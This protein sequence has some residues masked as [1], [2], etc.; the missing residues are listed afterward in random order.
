MAAEVLER[1]AEKGV[2]KLPSREGDL[3][4][5]AEALLRELS[6]KRPQQVLDAFVGDMAAG[7]IPTIAKNLPE[8]GE[9]NAIRVRQAIDWRINAEVSKAPPYE[10]VVSS[11]LVK[12]VASMISALHSGIGIQLVDDEG[13]VESP[14]LEA[15]PSRVVAR[16]VKRLLDG[17]MA[18]QEIEALGEDAL[19]ARYM[20]H[21]RLFHCALAWALGHELGHI[22]STESRRRRKEAPFQPLATELLESQ[23]EQ[24]LG[25]PRY[26]EALGPLNE[27]GRLRVFDRWLT[28]IN[29]D[30]IGASLA[31]G[32]ENDRG[33]SRGI[34]GVVAFTKLA[35]HLGLLSQH[36]LAA[37]MNLLDSRHQLASPTHPPMKLRMLCVLIWMYRDRLQEAT[38][39]PAGYV[40]QVFIE[41]L[42]QA[43]IPLHP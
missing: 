32:Y 12:F 33:P 29:A 42:Q 35:I 19:G 16:D 22:V 23:F 5:H 41:V 7:M 24:F 30:I 9:T 37:Y 25:D 38:A 4:G 18:E 40:Q 14:T 15:R 20:I 17:F 34:P 26:R 28:E 8:L 31:C 36:I 13:R 39:A 2:F 6:R 3:T 43:G 10:A 1:L 21:F 11:N 27:E